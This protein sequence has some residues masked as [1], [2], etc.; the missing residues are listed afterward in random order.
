[1]V[2]QLQAQKSSN[3]RQVTPWLPQAQLHCLMTPV[4]VPTNQRRPRPRKDTPGELMNIRLRS[5]LGPLLKPLHIEALKTEGPGSSPS[6]KLSCASP[7]SP[8]TSTSLS[9]KLQGPFFLPL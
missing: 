6:L 3:T 2:F 9:P 8:I 4:L 1:M 5:P 7:T